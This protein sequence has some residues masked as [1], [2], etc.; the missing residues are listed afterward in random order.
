MIKEFK[1]PRSGATGIIQVL[2]ADDL[3]DVLALQELTR[4]SLPDD[5]K[6]FVLPQPT[7]YFYNL[8]DENNGV[9]VG[10]RTGGQLIAQMA[11]MGA[12][13]V[14]EMIDRQKLTRNDIALHHAAP[15]DFAVI[16]K[17]MAVHPDFRGNELSQ[18]MLEMALANREAIP[19]VHLNAQQLD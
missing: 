8:L 5:Q 4:S 10:I 16:A 6:M 9:M 19:G 7:S 12:M 18:N 11:V 3:N 13:T 2:A 14:E 17:S 1:L 15:S